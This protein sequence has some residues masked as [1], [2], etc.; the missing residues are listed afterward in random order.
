[1][2]STSPT[3]RR[4]SPASCTAASRQSRLAR[5][6]ASNGAP[7]FS[8]KVSTPSKRL[9]SS[10]F[11]ANLF[12]RADCSRRRMFTPK[13][14]P[15][16]ISPVVTEVFAA[17]TRTSGGSSETPLKSDTVIPWI[18]SPDRAVMIVTPLG[19]DPITRRNSSAL[20]AMLLPRV[21]VS[22]RPDRPR[23]CRLGGES[24]RPPAPLH[25]IRAR[26]RLTRLSRRCARSLLRGVFLRRALPRLRHRLR[27]A[28]QEAQ[29]VGPHDVERTHAR[30]QLDRQPVEEREGPRPAHQPV[31]QAKA[32][33]A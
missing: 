9:N 17:Q 27:L 3:Q 29:H 10:F 7:V 25:P 31:R 20:I 8:T 2:V 13:Q 22:D 6:S 26:V 28:L 18:S 4:W 23:P 15:R 5:A 14:P 19:Q 33:H 12:E 32:A 11:E 24:D 1:M 30:R 21:S 16:S